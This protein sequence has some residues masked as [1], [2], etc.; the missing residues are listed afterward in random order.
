MPHPEITIDIV[1]PVY[2]GEV[3]LAEQLQ[4]LQ[5][6]SHKN[7]RLWIRDDASRD[8]SAEIIKHFCHQDARI[9]LS[10]ANDIRKNIGVISSINE[11]LT[12]LPPDSRYFMFCDQDDIWEP[13]KIEKNIEFYFSNSSPE[14]RE[15]P[16]LLFS[17]LSLIDLKG[18]RLF[19]SHMDLMEFYDASHLKFEEL[20]AQNIIV[21][22][23]CFG[24]AA[25]LK[26]ALPISSDAL[27]HDWWLGFFAS[28]KGKIIYQP[29]PLIKYRQHGQNVSGGAHK[30]GLKE[31]LKSFRSNSFYKLMNSRFEQLKA[32]RTRFER[33]SPEADR[34][35]SILEI[36]KLNG[37][38]KVRRAFDLG[39][40]PR[41][42]ERQIL[43]LGLLLIWKKKD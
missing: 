10:I 36:E 37:I 17:D 31:A 26:Q 38:S 28:L 30:K 18:E 33:A 34:I 25:L 11:L 19:S 16:C 32:L 39:F 21:G 14:E 23:T 5:K 4:S 7:W 41:G 29:E 12:Q 42:L 9:R 35:D 43:F 27:M 6:Q 13:F 15:K 22:C 40:F 24:N 3:F 1:M 2:N 8:N 20:C